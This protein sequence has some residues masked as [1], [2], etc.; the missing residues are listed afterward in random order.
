M[1]QEV[2]IDFQIWKSILVNE[3]RDI[4]KILSITWR[5][6]GRV[7]DNSEVICLKKLRRWVSDF[8]REFIMKY[9]RINMYK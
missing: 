4:K 5:L 1:P 2:T 3:E 8:S 9:K 7:F 6:R